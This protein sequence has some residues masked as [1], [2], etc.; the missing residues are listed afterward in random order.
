MSSAERTP[1][2]ARG[3]LNAAAVGTDGTGRTSPWYRGRLWRLLSAVLVAALVVVVLDRV[4]EV[5]AGRRLAGTIQS[6]QHLHDRPRVHIH[7]FPFVTQLLD[8]RYR[9]LSVDADGPIVAEGISINDTSVR[10]RDVHVTFHDA[11]HGTVSN[12]PVK[13]GT[14]AAVV[15]YTSLSAAVRRYGGTIG[16][17]LQVVGAGRGRARL[18]GPFGLGITARAHVRDGKLSIV[19]RRGDVEALPEP[20]RALVAT[21]LAGPLPLPPFPFNVKLAAGSFEPDGLHLSATSH[22]SVFPV[23]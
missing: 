23:R 6:V 5:V 7:G 18:Q 17:S 22:D 11:V 20:V 9:E 10:M 21:S 12:V 8:G 19:P 3:G 2:R 14:G 13:T 1:G 4:A 16:S 15:P